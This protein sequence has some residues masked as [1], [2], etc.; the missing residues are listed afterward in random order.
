MLL[1]MVLVDCA[2]CTR[3]VE[4]MGRRHTLTATRGCDRATHVGVIELHNY[5]M[6]NCS[7]TQ[8]LYTRVCNQ[9]HDDTATHC[10]TW[11]TLRRLARPL[12]TSLIAYSSSSKR[13]SASLTL[14]NV[15]LPRFWITTYWLTNSVPCEV[16]RCVRVERVQL[17]VV[18]KKRWQ[19]GNT[20]WMER[21]KG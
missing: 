4:G 5:S 3:R 15:P 1:R 2:C 7:S 20:Q 10:L 9:V 8:P 11:P 18:D 13:L 16:C 17:D 14:P 12:L 21:N 6:R 19:Q